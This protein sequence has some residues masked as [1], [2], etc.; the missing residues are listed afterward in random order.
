MEMYIIC[1]SARLYIFSLSLSSRRVN[2]LVSGC[3]SKW[4]R[5]R[6]ISSVYDEASV[7]RFCKTTPL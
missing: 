5:F 1:I 3:P 4:K 6:R 7:V 2:F